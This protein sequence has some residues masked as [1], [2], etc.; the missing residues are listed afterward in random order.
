MYHTALDA[1]KSVTGSLRQDA[2][3]LYMSLAQLQ[4]HQDNKPKAL[5]VLVSCIENNGLSEETVS[6]PRILKARQEYTSSVRD[7]ISRLQDSDQGS[8]VW[9]FVL[10]RISNSMLFEYLVGET[11]ETVLKWTESLV[12]LIRSNKVLESV[13]ELQMQWVYAYATGSTGFQPGL[14]RQVLESSLEKFPKNTVFLSL[15]GWN[16]AKT[17]IDNRVRRYLDSQLAR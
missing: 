17:R 2:E 1:F 9:N 8:Q 12:P 13:M 7:W 6:A 11:V 10:A 16:E 3:L 15:Y 14:V 4:F 5:A